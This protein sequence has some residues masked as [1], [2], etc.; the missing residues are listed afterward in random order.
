MESNRLESVHDREK[1]VS[2][3]SIGDTIGDMTVITVP[4]SDRN[5]TQ[6]S[7][8]VVEGLMGPGLFKR[9]SQNL[10]V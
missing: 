4:R 3:I 9:N 1:T 10:K 7:E 5:V 8:A 6:D 2:D